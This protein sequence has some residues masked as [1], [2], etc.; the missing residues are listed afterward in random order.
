MCFAGL[1]NS[2]LLYEE[3][4]LEADKAATPSVI[5]PEVGEAGQP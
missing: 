2:I 4:L 3:A 5:E 1:A